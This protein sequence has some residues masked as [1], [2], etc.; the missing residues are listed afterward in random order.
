MSQSSSQAISCFWK[1]PHCLCSSSTCTIFSQKQVFPPSPFSGIPFM[2]DFLL[3][4]DI[5]LNIHPS[6]ITSQQNM[7]CL[8][9]TEEAPHSLI[10]YETPPF[11]LQS[12]P[13]W[14]I[15]YR[16]PLVW[17]Q[18]S[19]AQYR[20]SSLLQQPYSSRATHVSR[21]INENQVDKA[22]NIF[23]LC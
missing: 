21:E 20:L 15:N 7:L 9:F 16:I 10:S 5:L 18:T 2:L 17:G 6:V 12:A 4:I 19:G 11:L 14:M 22:E 13:V 23:V 1:E 3:L 8:P